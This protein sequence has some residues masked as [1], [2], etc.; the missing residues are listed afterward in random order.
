MQKSNQKQFSIH[1]FLFQILQVVFVNIF[2][3]R[4]YLVTTCLP[5]FQFGWLVVCRG[6]CNVQ[7][8]LLSN[9]L[10]IV[11]R[12]SYPGDARDNESLA[13][14]THTQTDSTTKAT[15][16]RQKIKEQ[17]LKKKKKKFKMCRRQIL[18]PR[19]TK[20]TQQT[21]LAFAVSSGIIIICSWRFLIKPQGVSK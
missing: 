16:H 10:S 12:V 9:K 20:V 3:H 5:V 4:F 13:R 6:A 7:R 11:D 17:I 1:V 14:Y 21:R 2:N 8:E 18:Q 15:T 19:V